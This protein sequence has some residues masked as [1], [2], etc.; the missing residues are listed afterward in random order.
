MA[1]VKS[2]SVAAHTQESRDFHLAQLSSPEAGTRRLAARALGADPH[3]AA[4]LGDCLAS[5][6]EPN[7]RSALF[8]SLVS[9]GGPQ[10]ANLL[11]SFL[12]S[13][14]A[15]LRGGAVDALKQLQNSAIAAVD[16]LLSDADPDL[17]LLAIEVTRA[18]TCEQ[19]AP[20]LRRIF[21]ADP[22]VNVCAAA[23]DVATEA[24]GADLLPALALLGT[25]FKDEMFLC[26]AIEIAR[27][28]IGS[29]AEPDAK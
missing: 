3:A 27:A 8:A 9:I 22:H 16:E 29:L 11:A 6:R 14:D 2:L 28:R 20:R 21:E 13:D 19:A 26:F 23:V 10:T 5:E 24:G 4:T 18:W 17:R 12:K 1:F 25:R 7:V 15:A